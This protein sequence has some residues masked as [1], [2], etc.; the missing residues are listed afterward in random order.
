MA[1]DAA[2]KAHL[3]AR[4]PLLSGSYD[5]Y[6]VFLLLG[7]EISARQSSYCWIIPNKFLISDYAKAIKQHLSRS[8]GLKYSLDLSTHDVF[9]QAGVYPIVLVGQK[10][11]VFEFGEYD[12]ASLEALSE[13]AIVKR[14]KVPVFPTL[15]DAKIRV[16]SGATGF[17]AASLKSLIS[18]ERGKDR[19]P[20]VVSGWAPCTQKH[21][22][23]KARASRSQNGCSGSAQ[24]L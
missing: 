11:K 15:D 10:A 4:Y 19:I 6:V 7:S 14:S 12:V 1:R 20:F 9:P 13:R 18:E 23:P 17:Q 8:A 24:R 16:G 21:I 2:T 22:S 5:L 3:K